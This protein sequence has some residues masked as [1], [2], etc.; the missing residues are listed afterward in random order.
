[1]TGSDKKRT[2]KTLLNAVDHHFWGVDHHLWQQLLHR[3]KKQLNFAANK[4]Q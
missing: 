3:V 2:A 1:M 4:Y